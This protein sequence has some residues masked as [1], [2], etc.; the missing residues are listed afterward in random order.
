MS[1]LIHSPLPQ[2]TGSP[3]PTGSSSLRN[4]CNVPSSF[5]LSASTKLKPSTPSSSDSTRPENEDKGR[6]TIRTDSRI[7][8]L[9]LLPQTSKLLSPLPYY[10]SKT[11]HPYFKILLYLK[12]SPRLTGELETPVFKFTSGQSGQH[13]R[14]STSPCPRYTSQP[15]LASIPERSIH[16]LSVLFR[17]LTSCGRSTTNRPP[18]TSDST[19]SSRPSYLS[20]P[21][22][23][24]TQSS[25]P[26][27]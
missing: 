11:P 1:D 2:V 12:E 27:S 15:K 22:C 7:Y 25:T 23:I 4:R 10:L 16:D 18:D 21:P 19:L 20:P 17:S 3:P 14:R 24:T 9:I 26:S 8:L 13:N 6:A 5:R